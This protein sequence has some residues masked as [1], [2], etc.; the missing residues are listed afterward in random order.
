MEDLEDELLTS[1]NIQ[2]C[3]NCGESYNPKP[4]V[5]MLKCLDCGADMMEKPSDHPDGEVDIPPEAAQIGMMHPV[6]EDFEPLPPDGEDFDWSNTSPMQKVPTENPEFL[7][8]PG[9]G[10]KYQSPRKLPDECLRCGYQPPSEEPELPSDDYFEEAKRHE[11]ELMGGAPDHLRDRAYSSLHKMMSKTEESEK[12]ICDG[13]RYCHIDQE[14]DHNHCSFPLAIQAMH[15]RT[16]RKNLTPCCRYKESGKEP[17]IP[18]EAMEDREC[19]R[20]GATW[21][22]E[23][24]EHGT[25]KQ[26]VCPSCGC[27]IARRKMNLTEKI[28]RVRNLSDDDLIKEIMV[29]FRDGVSYINIDY[30]HLQRELRDRL[31]ISTV[32]YLYDCES[33]DAD[34]YEIDCPLNQLDVVHKIFTNIW[35]R[36]KL[37]RSMIPLSQKNAA[38]INGIIGYPYLCPDCGVVMDVIPY[39]GIGFSRCPECQ[40]RWVFPG[41]SQGNGDQ[42]TFLT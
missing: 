17:K 14:V 28:S 34:H 20:C 31:E 18:G 41:L 11:M 25:L 36:L 15:D 19:P 29:A 22:F 40:N 13:C 6:D 37:M 24:T 1:S 12:E 4:G 33:D 27:G 35:Q 9:C 5:F 21:P 3:P 2:R 7:N 39:K 10:V 23:E 38:M 16:N 8:C 26:S 42:R 30:L 32:E